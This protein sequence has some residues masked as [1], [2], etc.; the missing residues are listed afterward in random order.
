M[1]IRV[2]TGT[3]HKSQIAPPEI[4]R[5]WSGYNVG[6]VIPSEPLNG[7]FIHRIKL[8]DRKGWSRMSVF[9]REIRRICNKPDYR[10]DVLQLISSLPFR[11]SLEPKFLR[12]RGTA[13]VFAYTISLKQQQHPI[14]RA[15]KRL[16][17]RMLSRQIDCVIV[18]TAALKDQAK[19]MGF[20]TR[21]ETITNGVDLTRFHPAKGIEDR[22]AMRHAMG[23]PAQAPL[24]VCI[25]SLTSRKGSDIMLETWSR[26]SRRLPDAHLVFVGASFERVGGDPEKI[27]FTQRLESL[28]ANSESAGRLHFT[29]HVN[30][31]EDYYRS[32]DLL[33][34][35]S[36]KEGMPNAVIEAMA[37]GLPVVL[38]PFDSFSAEIGK[39]GRDFLLVERTPEALEDAAANL[40]RDADQRQR[41]GACARCWVEATMDIEV[42]LDRYL[43]LYREL[44][45]HRQHAA[46]KNGHR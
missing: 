20:D 3:P 21:I 24:L 37:S 27:R 29:G 18:G 6:S 5:K 9:S 39:P 28:I 46:G 42:T 25:G 1:S 35:P 12:Q 11:S 19:S 38:T 31:V 45:D 8:P 2:V 13:I 14:K 26:L 32:A 40:L 30:N 23:I 34:F 17:T 41:M 33:V 44:S 36:Q 43:N 4:V 22:I 7:A 10:P 15:V 16:H